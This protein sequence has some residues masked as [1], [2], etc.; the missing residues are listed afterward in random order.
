MVTRLER[1]VCPHAVSGKMFWLCAITYIIALF[2][3]MSY[4]AVMVAL[5][6]NGSMDEAQ[7]GL[8]GTALFVVY[9]VSQIFSGLIGDRISPK[10][11]IFVGLIGSG[12]LNL[13]MGLTGQYAVMLVVWA[14]NGLF[15][16]TMWSP[17]ARIFA[18]QMPPD[19]RKKCCNNIAVTYPL[20]TILAYVLATVLLTAWNWRGVFLLA[21]CMI[22]ITGINW[23]IRMSWFEKQIETSDEIEVIELQPKQTQKK[24]NMLRLLL[25]SGIVLAT[26]PAD[27][28]RYAARWHPDLAADLDDAE[29]PLWH[30]SVCCAGYYHSGV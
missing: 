28:A 18:E 1:R 29:F 14:L 11:M 25:L 8:I 12:I 26:I 30:V 22:I 5:I 27:D 9:G 21:G 15:Q 24:E 6:A 2:G 13:I 4:S 20:A 10:K 3:R 23:M 19:E 17:I 7:A 16:S